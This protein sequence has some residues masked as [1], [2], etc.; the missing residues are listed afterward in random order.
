MKH[1]SH[2][3]HQKWQ[4]LG[5]YDKTVSPLS[6]WATS[7]IIVM[8]LTITALFPANQTDNEF[9]SVFLCVCTVTLSKRYYPQVW[10]KELLL[11]VL[12]SYVCVC[13]QGAYVDNPANKDRAALIIEKNLT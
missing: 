5:N 4:Y 1:I 6:L 2:A 9:G 3:L 12:E 7:A 13:V 11:P 8:L 10:S